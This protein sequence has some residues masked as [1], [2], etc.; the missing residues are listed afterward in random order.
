[1]DEIIPYNKGGGP[2]AGLSDLIHATAGI[3]R[4]RFDLAVLF[5]N[6]F[7][8]ALLARLG[9]IRYRV[10]YAVDGRGFLL[11]HPVRRKEHVL[12]PHQVEYYLSIL[13][14]MGWQVR[15]RDPRLYLDDARLRQGDRILKSRG[16]GAEDFLVGLG[17][18]AIYGEAKRWPPDRFATIGDWAAQRWNARVLVFGSTTEQ[19]ICRDLC[20]SMENEPLNLCGRTSLGEAMATISRCSLFVTNDSGLMHIA[21][22][23]GVPT[24]AVFGSTD[25]AATGPRG[26]LTRV[27]RHDHDCA[28]CLQREC[29]RGYVCLLGIEPDEVW[30]AMVSL[31]GRKA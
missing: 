12:G 25:P 2:F 19:E 14:A 15:L 31:K 27:V 29:S 5:Q 18:G 22:A 1:V 7:E 30:E 21:V 24:V 10:G 4:G 9:G 3:R 13:R 6:A 20:R 17:P 28:P 8:A 26:P 23:V 11:T 16:F